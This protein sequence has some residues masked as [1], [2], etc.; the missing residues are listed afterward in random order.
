MLYAYR[1]VQNANTGLFTLGRCYRIDKV[2]RNN[3]GEWDAV[4]V[5]DNSSNS[6]IAISYVKDNQPYWV[7]FENNQPTNPLHHQNISTTVLKNNMRIIPVEIFEGT[8]TAHYLTSHNVAFNQNDI[9]PQQRGLHF[10]DSM[11]NSVACYEGAIM[12]PPNPWLP[13]SQIQSR[14]VKHRVHSEHQVPAVREL[15]DSKVLAGYTIVVPTNKIEVA[16]TVTI[17]HQIQINGKD[18]TL[19]TDDQLIDQIFKQQT[20]IE[21]L[22]VVKAKSKAIARLRSKHQDNINALIDILDSRIID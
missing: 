17:E 8:F 15:I 22:D 1:N 12:T 9:K 7:L 2:T 21:N 20:L 18:S 6:T 19:F 10:E 16:T 14:L 11:Y 4:V 13:D 5:N 3:S